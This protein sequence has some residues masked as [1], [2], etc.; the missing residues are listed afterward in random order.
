MDA[1][2]PWTTS[3]IAPATSAEVK[4]AAYL[5][6]RAAFEDFVPEGNQTAPTDLIYFLNETKDG[7]VDDASL[8][9]AKMWMDTTK[10]LN[11]LPQPRERGHGISARSVPGP[12]IYWSLARQRLRQFKAAKPA[13]LV[14]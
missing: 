3:G 6:V 5:I 13:V 4:V 12:L 7:S 11:A 14:A 1:P 8:N 9:S 10:S 2:G